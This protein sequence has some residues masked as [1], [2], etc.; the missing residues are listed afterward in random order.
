MA[1]LPVSSFPAGPNDTVSQ[2]VY[3]FRSARIA[4]SHYETF[5][6]DSHID[7]LHD[8]AGAILLSIAKD[9]KG[10]VH[11]MT[12]VMKFFAVRKLT[13]IIPISV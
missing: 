2:K 11:Q 6:I 8:T 12:N 1:A 13:E 5:L 3:I 7:I 9:L 10:S 4:L